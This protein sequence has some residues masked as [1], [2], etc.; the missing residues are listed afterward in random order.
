[1][2]IKDM[3]QEMIREMPTR[4]RNFINGFILGMASSHEWPLPKDEREAQE[5]ISRYKDFLVSTIRRQEEA[6]Y[7]EEEA[8]AIKQ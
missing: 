4:D 7:A 5:R 3:V 2:S 6:H 8:G 1:M